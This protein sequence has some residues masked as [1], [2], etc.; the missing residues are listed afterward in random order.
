MGKR[1]PARKAK[2]IFIENNPKKKEEVKISPSRFLPKTPQDVIELLIAF[3]DSVDLLEDNRLKF[4]KF[5]HKGVVYEPEIFVDADF[6]L[7]FKD[8]IRSAAGVHV[9]NGFNVYGT[10]MH[11]N[12]ISI[13]NVDKLCSE[14]AF[15]QHSLVADT[16]SYTVEDCRV[17]TE[18][19]QIFHNKMAVGKPILHKNPI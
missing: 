18:Q 2:K 12:K 13:E 3:N 1:I 5:T 17:I 10:F 15:F 19:I 9:R 16:N 11:P 8:G 7:H 6:S 4:H 14:E